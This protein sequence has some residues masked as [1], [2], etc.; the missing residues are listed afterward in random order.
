MP[1]MT[2]KSETSSRRNSLKRGEL[3]PPI[4]PAPGQTTQYVDPLHCRNNLE[5]TVTGENLM[6]GWQ[7]KKIFLNFTNKELI[8]TVILYNYCFILII[9]LKTNFLPFQK[10]PLQIPKTRNNK[11]L[12]GI[13]SIIHKTNKSDKATSTTNH[14]HPLDHELITS[15]SSVDQ[16]ET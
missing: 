5:E 2:W 8:H 7:K 12:K 15:L 14:S 10:L 4:S 1:V 13:N 11:K 16:F 3:K 6:S 9:Q